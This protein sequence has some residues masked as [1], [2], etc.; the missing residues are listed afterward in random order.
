VLGISRATYFRWK[1]AGKLPIEPGRRVDAPARQPVHDHHQH[2]AIAPMQML[3]RMQ[4]PRTEALGRCYGI[5]VTAVTTPLHRIAEMPISKGFPLL[6]P[7][8]EL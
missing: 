6:P 8:Y 3:A 5:T 4:R 7:H 1:K 2:R